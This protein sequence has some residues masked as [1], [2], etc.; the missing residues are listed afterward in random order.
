M[1]L[2][3]AVSLQGWSHLLLSFAGLVPGKQLLDHVGISSL[4]Q[5]RT[6]CSQPDSM[7]LCIATMLQLDVTHSSCD[8]WD[9]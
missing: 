3:H 1:V 5:H 8:P 4:W 9:P 6:H 2:T 7:L